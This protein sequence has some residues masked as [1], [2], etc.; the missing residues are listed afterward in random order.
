MNHKDYY[1]E[2]GLNAGP[3]QVQASVAH[4]AVPQAQRTIVTPLTG[5]NPHGTARKGDGGMAQ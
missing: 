5:G 1:G 2:S 4:G 3:S